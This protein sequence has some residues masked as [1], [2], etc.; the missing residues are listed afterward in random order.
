[1]KPNDVRR[2]LAGPGLRRPVPL[3][4]LVVRFAKIGDSS[5]DVD[6]MAWFPTRDVQLRRETP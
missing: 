3:N 6:V 1:M 2:T 4:R 5:L